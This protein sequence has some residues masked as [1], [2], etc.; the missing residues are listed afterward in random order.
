MRTGKI[1]G[2]IGGLSCTVLAAGC[3]ALPNVGGTLAELFESLL[4]GIL[5]TGG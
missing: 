2:L 4:G 1:L 5:G 3:D